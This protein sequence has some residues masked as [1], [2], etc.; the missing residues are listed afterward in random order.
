MDEIAAPVGRALEL[1]REAVAFLRGDPVEAVRH[2][3]KL[4]DL[5]ADSLAAA[6]LLEEATIGHAAGD[7]RKA[8]VARLFIEQRL[9]PPTRR[10][11]LP[12]Q[13]WAQRHFEA[14]VGYE[15]VPIDQ[16]ERQ[17]ATA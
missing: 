9:E 12:D 6:L 14:L 15:P 5:M 8:L 11:I 4:L 17:S 10:G 3:R 7:R 1:C 13:D 2:A 16:T